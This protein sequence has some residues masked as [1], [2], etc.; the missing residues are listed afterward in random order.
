M[1]VAKDD[2]KA[3][4]I[5]LLIPVINQEVYKVATETMQSVQ[6]TL[7]CANDL[8]DEII[9]GTVRAELNAYLQR[10][11]H[12]S[13]LDQMAKDIFGD[14]FN[15]VTESQIREI[16][17]A[18]F[19]VEKQKKDDARKMEVFQLTTEIS[20]DILWKSVDVNLRSV[21]SNAIK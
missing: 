5:A 6:E 12:Q 19:E 14:I 15:Q 17:T 7:V 10:E 18:E 3:S 9:E 13:K 1:K 20:K 8:V 4:C 16:V 11:I 2:I 21:A